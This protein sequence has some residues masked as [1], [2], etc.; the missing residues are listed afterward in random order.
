MSDV[1]GQRS[2]SFPG[3]GVGVFRG[4][5]VRVDVGGQQLE[6]GRQRV[7]G[8]E[9]QPMTPRLQARRKFYLAVPFERRRRSVSSLALA[10]RFRISSAE[11]KPMR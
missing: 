5:P 2:D 10:S 6:E 7:T 11:R 8:A 4:D 1:K 9:P 3:V